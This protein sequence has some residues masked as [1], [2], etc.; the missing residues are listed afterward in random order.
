M[1]LLFLCCMVCLIF[2]CAETTEQMQNPRP[3]FKNVVVLIGDDHTAAALGC[4]GNE[5]IHTPYLDRMASRGIRFSRAFANAPLC[6]ASR[7]SIL[8]GRYPHAAGVTLLRT[9]FP[10]EQVTLAEHLQQFGFKTVAIGKTHFNNGGKHGFDTLITKQDWR[11]QVVETSTQVTAL[12]VETRPQWKPFRDPARIWL[13][14]DKLPSPYFDADMEGS[15]YAEQAS[16]FFQDNRNERFL[17][18]VGFHEPHS[19]FDFPIEDTAVYRA[20][21]MLLPE[22][23]PEDDR[24]M[25]A[26]FKDLTEKDKRGIVASYYTS[27]S[28]LDKNVGRIL[29]HLDTMGLSDSTLVIYIGDQ[30][31][32]LGHHKRFEKH[33]MWEPAIHAPF[34]LQGGEQLTAGAERMTLTEFVDLTPTIL[35]A[36]GIKPLSSVQ[37]KSLWPVVTGAQTEH[38]EQVFSEFLAD[39]KAMIRTDRW[40]Y[41]FT[42]GKRDLGQGYATGNPPSGILHRLYDLENDPQE[43]RD[44]AGVPENQSILEDMQSRMIALFRETHPKADSIPPG[45]SVE[46]Q[47]VLFCEPPDENADLDAK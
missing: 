40:K 41:I 28:H 8:T 17:L 21:D 24:W 35:D 45:L 32:L 5:R 23:S 14:A 10:E 13:N 3:Q 16:H 33:M 9:S 1:R 44:V 30:G 20:T 29:S 15:Y 34:I 18:W 46:E 25:P 26:I 6:S 31:Y 37:G 38:K 2:A 19:P 22:T 27:V 36:L 7:Q 42:T 12:D 11:K 4:Y 43:L 39:N 47:L